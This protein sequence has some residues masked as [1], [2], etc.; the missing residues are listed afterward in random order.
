MSKEKKAKTKEKTD[1]KKNFGGVKP[2]TIQLF[3]VIA[4]IVIILGV[5][6]IGVGSYVKKDEKLNNIPIIAEASYSNTGE[7]VQ[8]RGSVILNNGD[9]YSWTFDG[10]MYEYDAKFSTKEKLVEYVKKSGNKEGKTVSQ[11]D[12]QQLEKYGRKTKNNIVLGCTSNSEIVGTYSYY[13][14]SN[15]SIIALSSSGQCSGSN[16]DGNAKEALKIIKKYIK[17]E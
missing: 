17:E 13:V 9:I 1:S 6:G 3:I 12:L 5:I 4:I 2:A 8:Y 15:D 11:E 10:P 14:K 16:D 7:T